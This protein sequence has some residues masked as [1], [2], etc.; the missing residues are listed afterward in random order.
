MEVRIVQHVRLHFGFGS[1]PEEVSVDVAR[2]IPKDIEVSGFYFPTPLMYAYS[3]SSSAAK[4]VGKLLLDP[5]TQPTCYGTLVDC[6]YR[7]FIHCSAQSLCCAETSAMASAPLTV[8]GAEHV[9]SLTVKPPALERPSMKVQHTPDPVWIK[10]TRNGSR[11]R[12]VHDAC[13]FVL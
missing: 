7:F 4:A 2:G 5:S 3:D 8:S 9:G 6:S 12:R 10:E 13:A 1:M 11:P